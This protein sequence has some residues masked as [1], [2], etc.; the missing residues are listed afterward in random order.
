MNATAYNKGQSTRVAINNGAS[1]AATCFKH[2]VLAYRDAGISV[3]SFL[4]GVLASPNAV[5]TPKPRAKRK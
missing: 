1:I 4:K 5:P 2:E 3:L